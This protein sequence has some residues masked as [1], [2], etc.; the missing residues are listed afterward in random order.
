ML[1]EIDPYLNK[2]EDTR[3]EDIRGDHWRDVDK[4]RED[5]SKIHSRRWD[6]YT[7]DKEE[8]LKRDFLVSVLHPNGGL[9]V[10]VSRILS[11]RKRSNTIILD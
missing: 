4:G 10:L 2:Y 3:M 11:S 6:V 7:I 1:E 9:F 8:I 5:K